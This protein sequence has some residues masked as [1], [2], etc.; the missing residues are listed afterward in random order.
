MYSLHQQKYCEPSTEKKKLF[1]I[2]RIGG[3]LVFS[4]KQ[5]PQMS[6][7]GIKR[8]NFFF[9]SIFSE[10]KTENRTSPFSFQASKEMRIVI[11]TTFPCCLSSLSPTKDKLL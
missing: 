1:E 11:F 5:M 8:E 6:Q 10:A 9:F 3:I 2:Y 4:F 7:S